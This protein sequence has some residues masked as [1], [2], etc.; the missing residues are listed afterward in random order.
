MIVSDVGLDARIDAFFGEL[1]MA[2]LR[3][4]GPTTGFFLK[5]K[6]RESNRRALA[7]QFPV[8][9]EVI[10]DMGALSDA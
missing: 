10:A 4:N 6:S 7:Y 8:F 3:A 2:D 9:Y 5:I 1:E